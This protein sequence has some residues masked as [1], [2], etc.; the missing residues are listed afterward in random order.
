MAA[1]S[2]RRASSLIQRPISRQWVEQAVP[3]QYCE[4]SLFSRSSDVSRF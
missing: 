4:L 2:A 3:G 1:S